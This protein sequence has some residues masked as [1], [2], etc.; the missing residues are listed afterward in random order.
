VEISNIEYT[1][2]DN[3]LPGTIIG[4]SIEVGTPIKNDTT[5]ELVVVK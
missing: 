2:D 1:E 5:I 3:Y 4:Q